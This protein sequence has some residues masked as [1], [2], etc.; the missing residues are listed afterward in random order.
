MKT[1]FFFSVWGVCCRWVCNGGS[2][3]LVF[4]VRFLILAWSTPDMTMLTT[5]SLEKDLLAPPAFTGRD[6]K[7]NPTDTTQA[8]SASHLDVATE[9]ERLDRSGLP[10]TSL[11]ISEG[12]RIMYSRIAS[13]DSQIQ[14]EAT[15][16]ITSL[17]SP[18]LSSE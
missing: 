6:R 15:L 4:A 5:A 12:P 14:G 8:P 16:P 13:K 17:I 9:P 18:K 7:T 3:G 2:I 11:L 1:T 10:K